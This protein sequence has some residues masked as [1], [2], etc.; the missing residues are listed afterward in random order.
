M[1]T[2]APPP[3]DTRATGSAARCGRVDRGPCIP[4]PRFEPR[5]LFGPVMM[6]REKHERISVTDTDTTGANQGQENLTALRMAELRAIA[7]GKG[8]RGISAMRKHELL[9][10]IHI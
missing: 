1:I 10:L 7:S 9:S 6:S 5:P 8:I 2:A 4:G 3:H